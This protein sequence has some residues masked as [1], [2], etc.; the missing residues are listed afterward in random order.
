MNWNLID[1]VALAYVIWGIFRGYR[2][3]VA[4]ELPSVVGWGVSLFTGSGIYRWTMR[5]FAQLSDVA[6]QSFGAAG[7]VIV[8]VGSYFLIRQL[9]RHIRTWAEKRV[10]EESLQK[11]L[12]AA[13][14]GFRALLLSSFLILFLGL[15]PVGP[16]RE[17]FTKDSFV[18]RVLNTVVMPVYEATHHQKQEKQEKQETVTPT[19]TTPTTTI[20]NNTRSKQY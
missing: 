17:P 18:G 1:L 13:A 9:R 6:G 15:L 4:A 7:F 14:G 3:G 5:G 19:N 11:K 12:G 10:N 2:R 20:Y 8:L 16:L